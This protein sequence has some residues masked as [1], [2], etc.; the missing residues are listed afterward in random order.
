MA[1]QM[2][3]AVTAWKTLL[4]SD[5]VLQ[6]DVVAQRYGQDTS[7]AQRDIP[8][9]LLITDAALLPAVMRIAHQYLIAVHPISTGRNWGYGSALPVRN[10]T[11]ILDLSRLNQII[12][13]DPEL[14]VVTV[15]PGVTQGMLASF[16]AAGGHPHMVPVTGAGPN[17]S[18]LGNAL[19][20]GYGI[21]P[22]ADHFS[23]VT[24]IEAVLADGSIYKTALNEAGGPELARLFKWGLGP[25]ATGLFTQGSLGIVTRMSILLARRPDCV[26]VCLF[27]LKS[28]ALLEPAVEGIRSILQ[29]LPGIV[30]GINLMNRHRV[31]SMAAPYPPASERDTRGLMPTRLVERL[32][33]EY[34]APPWTGFAT[35]YG[36]RATVKAAQAEMRRALRGTATRMLFLSQR[37][38]RILARLAGW[39]PGSAGEKLSRTAATLA[40]ALDLA[41]GTPNQTALPLAYWRIGGPRTD[42]TELNPARDGCGLSWYAPLVPMRPA[43]VRRYVE[44]ATATTIEHGLEPLITLTSVG[45]RLFD[46]TVPLVFDRSDPE[47]LKN[48]QTCLTALIARGCEAGFHPYRLSVDAMTPVMQRTP[49]SSQLIDRLKTALDPHVLI[50]PGRYSTAQP[51]DSA[52]RH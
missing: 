6:G 24:D 4:G 25:Y 26:R 40:S 33:R 52:E 47:A 32:G 42:Q 19:E 2:L 46:S 43:D 39:I 48:A 49:R 9:A 51:P 30:G 27:N 23:A 28:D 3:A 8:A 41:A 18:L 10:D 12:D 15:E 20:R 21:T 29:R 22:H 38:A 37:D 44:L 11:C 1:S 13:F 35:L 16:L 45:E 17:C 31:L 5:K 36:T 7:G 34:Q 14:G 50:D